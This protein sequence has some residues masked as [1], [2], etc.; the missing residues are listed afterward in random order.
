MI[1]PDPRSWSFSASLRATELHIQH[2]EVDDP[3]LVD[4]YWHDQRLAIGEVGV[5]AAR[6]L[7]PG[8]AASLTIPIRVVRDRIQFQDLSGQTY[9][10]PAPD[11]HHRNET[12]ARLADPQIAALITGRPG[13]WTLSVGLGVSIPLGRTEENPFALGR[14][15]V[16]HQHIQ[17]GTGTFDPIV[18][19]LAAR[20][21]G[22][23]GFNASGSARWS[24]YENSHGYQGPSRFAASVGS[25]RRWGSGWGTGLGLGV[26]RENAERWNGHIEQ[27]GNI[28]RTDLF[29][30]IDVSR[31][32]APFGTTALTFQVPIKTWTTGEQVEFPYVAALTWSR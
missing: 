28:G 20:Q 10:P 19:A 29:A 13:P 21:V 1:A 12:L 4:P 27:E 16:P 6:G 18:N 22:L 8:V 2:I 5:S 24:L 31:T 15:G 25:N 23:F 11:T 3:G 7:F 9:T 30:Q 32:R 26:F 17:F 14:E